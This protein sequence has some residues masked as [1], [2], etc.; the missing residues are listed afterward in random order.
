MV[1]IKFT[2]MLWDYCFKY[3][4]LNIELLFDWND[5]NN[6]NDTVNIKLKLPAG[7]R[8]VTDFINWI[9]NLIDSFEQLIH[10]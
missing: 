6:W 3:T 8:K 1:W 2:K 10:S 4:I 5:L 9:I 7:E